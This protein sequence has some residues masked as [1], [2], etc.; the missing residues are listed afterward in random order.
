LWD[1]AQNTEHTPP[2]IPEITVLF[3]G[4]IAEQSR[5]HAQHLKQQ[6]KQIFPTFDL[7]ARAI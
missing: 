4:S 3:H 5:R 6:V 7:I 2:T 1:D